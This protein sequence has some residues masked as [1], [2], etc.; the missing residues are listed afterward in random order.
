VIDFGLS[1]QF[2][3]VHPELKT[4]C[5]SPAYAS[6]EMVRGNLYTRAADI[7]SAGILLYAIIAG[8]LPFDDEN[9]QRLL[10]KIVY[11]EPK[12]PGHMSPPLIDLLQ[13]MICKDPEMRIDLPG[14]VMHP[15]F[16]QTEYTGMQEM[17]REAAQQC[18]G[19]SEI[20]PGIIQLMIEQGLDC[21]G[22]HEALL[23]GVDT[24]LSVIYRILA[25]RKLTENLRGLMQRIAQGAKSRMLGGRNVVGTSLAAIGRPTP[26]R[27]PMLNVTG[28]NGGTK[29]VSPSPVGGK[30]TPR[31]LGVPVV[32]SGRKMSRPAAIRRPVDGSVGTMGGHETP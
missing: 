5:G 28:P 20:D 12:F 32:A 15:W 1:S 7:W 26:T 31:M 23:T 24:D 22:L 3:E 21:H 29:P 17:A 30:A 8:E 19:E 13:K 10:Q 4:A 14:I 2:T 11:T 9:V 27:L 16:S 25:R 6:P 18:N